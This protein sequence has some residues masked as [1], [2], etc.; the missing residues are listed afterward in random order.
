MANPQEMQRTMQ[1]Q[2]G[3]SQGATTVVETRSKTIRG[4]EVAITVSETSSKGL[5][6]RQWM[7]V[8]EGNAGPTML[9]IQGSTYGWDEEM[10]LEFIRSIR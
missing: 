8:S 6:L 10:I 1:Q 9:M 5:S 2:S 3:Q 7:T 4:Q